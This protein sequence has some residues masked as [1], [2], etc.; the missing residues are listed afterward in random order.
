M[1]KIGLFVFLRSVLWLSVVCVFLAVPW[2]GLRYMSEALPCHIHLL[3]DNSVQLKKKLP[4]IDVFI[5]WKNE[6]D[7]DVR[8]VNSEQWER[9]CH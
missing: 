1:K 9:I 4:D 8:N 3:C 2:V 5:R 6:S 7:Q